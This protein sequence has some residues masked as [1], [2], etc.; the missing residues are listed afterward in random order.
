VSRKHNT[1]HGR[2]QSRYPQRLLDR[3][4]TAASVRMPFICRGWHKHDTAKAW[5]ECRKEAS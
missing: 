1:K 2:S 4:E 5:Q 3:G